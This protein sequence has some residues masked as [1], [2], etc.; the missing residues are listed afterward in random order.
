MKILQLFPAPADHSLVFNFSEDE[1]PDYKMV[2][3][4]ALA[5]TE[6][7]VIP[8]VTDAEGDI[9]FASEYAACLGYFNALELEQ[10]S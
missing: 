8:L 5:L 1:T 3:A 9:V 2:P 10:F 6:R 7:G 4:V